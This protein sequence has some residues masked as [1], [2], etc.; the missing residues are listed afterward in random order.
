MTWDPCVN[1]DYPDDVADCQ[2]RFLGL[3]SFQA[4]FRKTLAIDSDC[5]AVR[6]SAPDS[7]RVLPHEL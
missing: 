4:L 2:G 5:N 6:L 7:N 3:C 1:L